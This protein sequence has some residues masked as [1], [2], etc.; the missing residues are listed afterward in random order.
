MG[1]FD[2]ALCRIEIYSGLEQ[3]RYSVVPSQD[4]QDTPVTIA[5]P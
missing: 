4:T 2:D 5:I 1:A 3:L